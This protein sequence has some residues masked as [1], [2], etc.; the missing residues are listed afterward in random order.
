MQQ[1]SLKTDSIF[2]IYFIEKPLED[3]PL[4]FFCQLAHGSP[5]AMI[6]APKDLPDLYSTIASQFGGIFPEDILYCTVNTFKPEM[7]HLLSSNLNLNDFIFA[8][9]KGTKK[10][11]TLTKTE[12]LIGVTLTDNGDGKVFIKRIH[13][14]S[15]AARSK[16]AILVGDHVEK[17]NGE[18]VVGLRHY[19]VAA[20]LRKIPEGQDLVLRLIEPTKSGFSFIAPRSEYVSTMNSEKVSDGTRTVRFRSTGTAVLQ[21]APCR[22]IMEKVNEIFETYLGF[23]DDI[24]ALTGWEI[25]EKTINFVDLKNKILEVSLAIFIREMIVCVESA[26]LCRAKIHPKRA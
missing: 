9:I 20:M 13:E 15:I 14:S 5:T 4:K 17:I 6:P 12:N 7:E 19:S 25:A 23:N 3:V 26:L 10:E 1:V 16:P 22:S 2:Q 8:H 11:V 18:S 21:E 24:L